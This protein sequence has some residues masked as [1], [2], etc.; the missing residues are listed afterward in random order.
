MLRSYIKT[1]LRNIKKYKVYSFI[2]IAGLAVGMACCI[3]I[4]LWIQ[5]EL[6]Y[7]RF[8]DNTD[9]I[10]RVVSSLEGEWTSTSPW[11]ISDVL[12]DDFPEIVRST[13][14]RTNNLLARYEESSHYEEVG[15]V[16]PD[17]LHMFSFPLLQG[18]PDTALSGRDSIILSEKASRRY[19]R[20]KDPVGKILTVN[21]NIDLKVT[22]VIQNI[23]S[24]STL[25][26]DVLVPVQ[27]LGEERLK[28][29]ALETEAFV[30]LEEKASLKDLKSK[31]SGTTMKYDKRIEN[32]TVINDLQPLSRMHLYSLSGGGGILY[33]YIFAA[34]A[35]IILIVACIN[36]INL[37]TAKSGNRAVE[38]GLR[39]VV[40]ANRSHL[41]K[42][43]FGES[44]AIS[45]MAFVLS[46]LLVSLFLPG[47]N[48]LTQK[49]LA[50][51]PIHNVPLILSLLGIAFFTGVFSGS[52]PAFLFSSFTPIQALRES[53]ALSLKSP[54]LRRV[55][56]VFQF[57]VAVILI[58]CSIVLQRQMNYIRNKDL[59]FNRSYVLRLPMN[60]EIQS[61]YDAFKQSLLENSDVLSVTSASNVP[62]SIGNINPVYWEGRGPDQYEVINF[63][64]VDYDYFKTFQMEFTEGRSFSR[65]FTTDEQNYIINE[66]AVR[67]TG[68]ESP[69]GKLFSIWRREGRI[70]GV[71]KDFHS[72]S[73][74]DEIRPVV[75]TLTTNWP[76]N[77]I[78][79]RM[80][81]ERVQS[82]L[83][84]VEATWKQFAAV[85]PFEFD[86][87]D[88]IFNRQ[89]QTDQR[90]ERI[91]NDFT[92]LAIF[93]SCLGLF[94]LASYMAERR[95]K[96]IGIRKVL[97]AS[98]SGVVLM[99]SRD[100]TKW[101]LA[102]NVIAL[103]IAWY[104]ASRWMQNYAYRI[105]ISWWV[106]LLS[107]SLALTI[108]LL[109]VG[110]QS[111]RSALANPADSIRYE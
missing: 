61:H 85:Y 29:W 90:M 21:N 37:T 103:P 32:K 82:A 92:F 109:T 95:T 15:F 5:D 10:Y 14:F 76:H 54:V 6:S 87:L 51:D 43:F 24:N 3:L 63:T 45:F 70:I 83:Q 11:A 60:E 81:P 27:I 111:L 106:Y 74:H 84:A 66:A 102:A 42:Q 98:V 31:I 16:D 65:D 96:E 7:D 86:F 39:K 110:Y 71:V 93:I 68:L 47:F 19:F 80:N 23:P 38:V 88:D 77:Y 107:G 22:G 52:Y 20:D 44:V 17:F 1:A 59:G 104:I 64:A 4:F 25:Q 73:L 94:G 30:M 46:L 75:F 13:R 67:F 33:I 8:H 18:N 72:R 58:F 34:I 97:G 35:V 36:F 53:G 62:L 101:V 2:N 56:V 57:T 40:G 91:I 108:A 105:S 50:F 69:L 100:F 78:F 41:I 9:R 55:L 89:Y 99:L 48:N 12:K 49:Q 28:T 26:F 79:V